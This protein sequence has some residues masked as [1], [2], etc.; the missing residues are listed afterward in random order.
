MGGLRAPAGTQDALMWG[1]WVEPE[2]RGRG[3]GALILRELLDWADCENRT[4]VLHVTEGNDGARRL[5]EMNG[6]VSTGEW[7]RLRDGSEI[8]METMRR[9]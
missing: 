3:L 7:Q 2:S 6:F 5:Y 4:I 1:M 8:R 9:A